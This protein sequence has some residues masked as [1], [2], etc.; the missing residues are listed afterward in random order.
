MTLTETSGDFTGTGEKIVVTGS[1]DIE[2]NIADAMLGSNGTPATAT[3]GRGTIDASDH[4][5]ELTVDLGL[6]E[7]ENIDVGAFSGVDVLKVATDDAGGIANQLIDV[8]SGMKVVLTGSESGDNTFQLDPKGT[9][10]SD[11]VTLELNH[12]TAG[13][14]I[15]LANVIVDGFEKVTI[16][17]TGTN[18]ATATVVNILESLDGTTTDDELVITGDKKLQIDAIEVTCAP[19]FFHVL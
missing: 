6:L 10:T 14:I 2:L 18:T 8:T 1:S 5:G 12:D 7:G 16:S 17:S 15:D 19:S 4:T 13:S 3:S 9:G 11:T